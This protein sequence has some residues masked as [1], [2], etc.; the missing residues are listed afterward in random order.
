MHGRGDTRHFSSST[1]R[2]NFD[3][4]VSRSSILRI[5]LRISHILFHSV[6]GPRIKWSILRI[7]SLCKSCERI[8]PSLQSR[9]A[10]AYYT[11]AILFKCNEKGSIYIHIRIY[12]R[13]SFFVKNRS[14]LYQLFMY[15]QFFTQQC[16]RNKNCKQNYH[17]K[18]QEFFTK[19]SR[20]V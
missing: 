5:L 15:F 17:E 19:F 3:I 12:W 8:W 13:I 7:S 10:F 6:C 16:F 11:L 4:P 14:I 20:I 9:R 18:I 1:N 2:Q